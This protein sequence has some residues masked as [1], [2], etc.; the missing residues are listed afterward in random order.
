MLPPRLYQQEDSVRAPRFDEVSGYGFSGAK[1]QRYYGHGRVPASKL[2]GAK[3]LE[4]RLQRLVHK[5]M[6]G[7]VDILRSKGLPQPLK[8]ALADRRGQHDPYLYQKL[9][10]LNSI[11]SAQTPYQADRYQTEI[12]RKETT[13]KGENQLHLEYTLTEQIR[14]YK[15]SQKFER[16]RRERTQRIG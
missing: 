1:T 15:D 8:A 13:R 4:D 7:F 11:E 2:D 5:Q 3:L 6:R 10:L 16:D 12:P 9:Q 14:H